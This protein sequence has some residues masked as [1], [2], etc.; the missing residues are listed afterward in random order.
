MLAAG[1]AAGW[2][3]GL[4]ALN[5]GFWAGVSASG[6]AAVSAAGLNALL[7][8]FPAEGLDSSLL[9]VLIAFFIALF[10][11]TEFTL[12][13]IPEAFVGLKGEAVLE[14]V[15]LAAAVVAATPPKAAFV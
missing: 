4:N 12:V 5:A 6:F 11:A 13:S 8:G 14:F 10:C 9:S 3:A 2:L 1:L 15:V 7:I